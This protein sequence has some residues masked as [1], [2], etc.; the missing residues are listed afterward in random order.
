MAEFSSTETGY[1]W[2]IVTARMP[3]LQSLTM[4][5][6][7]GV[8]SRHESTEE[9][10]AAHFV[11]HLLFKGTER[12][13]PLQLALDVEGLGGSFNAYTSEDSTQLEMRGPSDLMPHL[14]D[15]LCDMAFHSTFPEDELEREREVIEEEIILY[16]ESPGEH[17][18][19]LASRAM[20]N[21]HPLGRPILGTNES[22]AS[23]D[24]AQLLE[25][26]TRHYRQPGGVIA[27]AG[28]LVHGAV[29]D[30]FMGLLP[31]SP[32]PRAADPLAFS[33][34]EFSGPNLVRE[35]RPIEQFHL[36]LGFHAPGRHSD[37]RYA[38]KL[39]SL[40]LGETMS[41]RLF[42]EIR[43]KRGLCYHIG[44]DVAQFAETGSFQISAGLDAE[45]LD[46]AMEAIQ[47]VLLTII[48][49]GPTHR[50]LEQAKRYLVGQSR[51]GLETSAAHMGWI[52]DSMLYYRDLESP[53]SV[54][55][56]Y[57]AVS[58]DEVHEI[59]KTLFQR[60]RLGIALIGPNA[61]SWE[62]DLLLD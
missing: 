10:G 40:L 15:V 8:G 7:V 3:H 55:A 25:F 24:Q 46:V 31:N 48:D 33:L 62:P 47:K 6:S 42:Q 50:E 41:S 43:E 45:R 22:L 11:E 12:R 21:D 26:Q 35:S 54:R 53:A 20:W 36:S 58:R 38:M 37:D 14:A 56:R 18:G 61:E 2:T 27:V 29:V 44:T 39:L 17:L 57:L 9:A 19:D 1:G 59:A 13:S 5:L 34:S 52:A 51:V 28:D 16:Q 60:S 49:E 32:L 30:T 23:L 4:G